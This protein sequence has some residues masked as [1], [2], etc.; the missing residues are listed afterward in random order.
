[1]QSSQTTVPG[2]PPEPKALRGSDPAA[3]GKS[4]SL[5]S[6]SSSF[7]PAST[8]EGRDCTGTKLWFTRFLDHTKK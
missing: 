7:L 5:L 1:M 6:R 2:R 4:S 8:A 3:F